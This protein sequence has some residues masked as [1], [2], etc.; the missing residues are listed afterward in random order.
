VTD[1]VR[2]WFVA[3]TLDAAW[4]ERFAARI[5][6]LACAE[7]VALRIT[8]RP[9]FVASGAVGGEFRPA[10]ADDHATLRAGQI[11]R[12]SCRERVS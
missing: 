1:T 8:E 5:R 12:A 11:G 9:E 2:I 3:C 6:E 4:P 10:S 7:H